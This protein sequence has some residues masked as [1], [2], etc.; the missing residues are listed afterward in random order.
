MRTDGAPAGQPEGRLLRLQTQ[1]GLTLGG[2]VFATAIVLAA[3]L[4]S[5]A[6][7]R[8][9]RISAENLENLSAQMARELSAGMDSFLRDVQDQAVRDRFASSTSTVASMRAALDQFQQN[10]PEFAYVSI[11]DVATGRVIAANGGIFEGGSASERPT[12]EQGKLAPYLGDVHEAVRLAELL[13][14]PVP[15]ETLRFLDV[16]APIR[17]ASGKVIRV[18]ASHIG[19][20]WTSSVHDHVFGPIGDQRGIDA[21]IVDTRGKVVMS[22][23]ASVPVGTDLRAMVGG[24]SA[25]A[26]RVE[27]PDQQPYLTTVAPVAPRGDFKGFGWKVVAREPYEAAY[28]A[29]RDLRNA[30]ML[31]ALGLGLFAAFLAWLAAGRLTR[32]VRALADAVRTGQGHS[33]DS[34]ASTARVGEVREVARAMTSLTDSA[35]RQAEAAD[36]SERQFAVLA[37]SLPQLVWEADAAG[38]LAYVNKQWLRERLDEASTVA[39]LARVIHLDDC[40]QFTSAWRSSVATGDPLKVRCR[41]HVPEADQPVWH[42]IEARAVNAPG[43]GVLRW[44]GTMFD[45][46]DTVL[47]AERTER[48]LA[49]ER[50]AREEAERLSRMRDEFMATVSHELRSPLSAITG[51]SDILARKANADETLAKAAQVIRRNAMLQAQLIDDL[52]DMTAVMAGKLTLNESVFDLS[53]LAKE[54]TLSHL[55]AAQHKGVA[56][57]C[58]EAVPAMVHG[59]ERRVSQVLSNLIVNGIK[60]TDAGGRVEV[61]LRTDHGQAEVKVRDTGRGISPT[62]LPH[63]FERLR[64]EDAS[65][66]RKAGGLGIGL[67]IAKAVVELHHGTIRAHSDGPSTGAEFTFTLAL[68]EHDADPVPAANDALEP[69]I[70]IDL[71]EVSV[72][73]VDDEQDAREVG[74][75]ALAS[76]GARVRM[77]ASATEALRILQGERFDLLVSDIGM[78]GMDGLAFVRALRAAGS[79]NADIPAVALSAFALESEQAEGIAAGFDAYVSKPISL[80]RLAK[81]LADAQRRRKAT[82]TGA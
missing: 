71:S 17:D 59:D 12:F 28:A 27:W 46:N 51:W 35:R 57:T 9:L 2:L 29:A 14:K 79:P 81:G 25:A 53:A 40:A 32:P 63:V 15:G 20:D 77:A 24:S 22:R 3:V 37:G 48:R 23:V 82:R 13:P 4:S 41:L 65:K 21:F 70:D 47:A 55:H 10:H 67:A 7:T 56:L 43:G 42:D 62:F 61:S 66:S 11:V 76:M 45:V 80:R 64:Q 18:F 75:I 5:T 26:Q 8:V 16:A 50:S 68:V 44:I 52:L 58:G 34:V 33:F 78:P 38:Q 49:Q 31:G 39:D 73:L 60:F 30:F 69:A 1:V 74:Q 54:V 19:W 36:T 72:L 6:E